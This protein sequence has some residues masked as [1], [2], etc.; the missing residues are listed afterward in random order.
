MDYDIICLTEIWLTNDLPFIH[1][2]NNYNHYFTNRSYNRGG[3]VLIYVKCNFK[4]QFLNKLSFFNNILDCI[5]LELCIEK[6]TNIIISAIYRE[7]CRN[8]VLGI[9][10]KLF[11]NSITYF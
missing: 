11:L 5:T 8:E 6:Y 7:G 9:Q 2:I 10:M 4:I 1:K 3:D